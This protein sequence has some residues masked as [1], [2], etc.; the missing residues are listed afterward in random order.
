LRWLFEYPIN[1]LCVALGV[2]TRGKAR[3]VA[4]DVLREI[5]GSLSETSESLIHVA[6]IMGFD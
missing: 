2:G 3:V 4:T 1:S 5:E 6:C